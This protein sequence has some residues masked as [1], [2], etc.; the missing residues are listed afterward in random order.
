ME[1]SPICMCFPLFSL[2][3]SD[4]NPQVVVVGTFT[5]QL[6]S[7]LFCI[8][9][10]EQNPQVVRLSTARLLNSLVACSVEKDDLTAE[11]VKRCQN[12]DVIG[13]EICELEKKLGLGCWTCKKNCNRCMTELLFH[14]HHCIF[15]PPTRVF[16]GEDLVRKRLEM[17]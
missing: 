3:N 14:N 17:S 13:E 8:C 12:E 10:L 5:A 15:S 1:K 2:C 16:E 9:I 7:S 11:S 4:V 6:L